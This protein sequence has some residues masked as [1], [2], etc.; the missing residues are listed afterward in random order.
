LARKEA[1]NGEFA[2]MFEITDFKLQIRE[3]LVDTLWLR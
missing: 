3:L 1:G 2:N